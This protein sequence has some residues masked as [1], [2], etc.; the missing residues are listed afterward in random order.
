MSTNK[1]IIYLLAQPKETYE[2]D[3]IV[4]IAKSTCGM[5][6]TNFITEA[7]GEFCDNHLHFKKGINRLALAKCLQET[8]DAYG[9]NIFFALNKKGNIWEVEPSGGYQHVIPNMCKDRD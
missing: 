3:Q 9:H 8:R 6:P 5:I 2:H 1:K 4:P 7:G